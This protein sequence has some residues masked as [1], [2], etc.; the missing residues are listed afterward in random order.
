MI[1]VI[2]VVIII[3]QP[4]VGLALKETVMPTAPMDDLGTAI[5][6]LLGGTVGGDITFSGAPRLIDAGI[7][8]KENLKEINRR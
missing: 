5:L 3:V 8:K 7:T 2:F 1:V 6:T 4:P